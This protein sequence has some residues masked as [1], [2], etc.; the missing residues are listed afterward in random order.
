MT[1]SPADRDVWKAYDLHANCYIIKPLDFRQ[2]VE[3]IKGI[4]AF[5]LTLARLPPHEAKLTVS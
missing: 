2:F 5:W 3:L 1:T 4:E